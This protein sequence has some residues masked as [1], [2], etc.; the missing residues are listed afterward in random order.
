MDEFTK[1]MYRKYILE[2]L[3]LINTIIRKANEIDYDSFDYNANT[4][5]Q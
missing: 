5:L 1:E 4:N 3:E 2:N